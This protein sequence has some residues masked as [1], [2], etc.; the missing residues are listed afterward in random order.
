MNRFVSRSFAVLCV[1]GFYSVSAI[2]GVKPK[3]N[4]LP[5]MLKVCHKS[6]PKVN[7]CVKQSIE[8]LRPYL[9]Q[10]IPELSIPPC[11]PL[12]IPEVVM[13]QG[14][15]SV[16]VQSTYS[17]I[18]IYGPS[19]FVLKSVKVDFE[20]DRMRLKVWLPFLHM[21]SEYTIDGRILMLPITGKGFSE[22]NYTD[23]EATAVVQ[24]EKIHI[25]GKTYFN[26]VDFFCDFNIGHASVYLTD[27]FDGDKELGDAMNLFLNDNWRNVAQEIK[28]VL[29]ETVANLFKKFANKLFHKYPLDEI[30]PP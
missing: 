14:K 16:A 5:P 4:K 11:E 10:G 13:N 27:L 29:E 17:N 12:F 6:D 22:G 26:V 7:E 25:D 3:D 21:N 1:V 18:K 23:I 9:V 20:K 28:P 2:P 30:L 8:Q 24:G 15:G 19:Q